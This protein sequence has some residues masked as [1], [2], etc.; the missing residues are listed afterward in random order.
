MISWFF[1]DLLRNIPFDCDSFATGTLADQEP[2]QSPSAAWK[3]YPGRFV[4]GRNR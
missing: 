2:R 3:S 4:S 1:S